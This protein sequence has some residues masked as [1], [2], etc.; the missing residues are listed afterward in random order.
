MIRL[1]KL[2]LAVF[3][4]FTSGCWGTCLEARAELWAVGSTEKVRASERRSKIEHSVWDEAT[5]TVLL[6][7]ARGEHVPFQM[8]L[9][10]ETAPIKDVTF[11]V[12][13]L[14]SQ[15]ASLQESQVELFHGFSTYLHGT[16]LEHSVYLVFGY[17]S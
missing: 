9:T 13:E 5:N 15:D 2:A 1:D 12:S 6:K 14:R 10:A 7:G 16:M 8:V 4:S 11:T 3:F 17:C